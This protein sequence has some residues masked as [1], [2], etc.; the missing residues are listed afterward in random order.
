MA[1]TSAAAA[2]QQ[3]APPKPLHLR[4][5]FLPLALVGMLFGALIS[6]VLV[7]WA[8]MA[9]GLWSLPGAAHAR[10]TLVDDIQYLNADFTQSLFGLSPVELAAMAG[11]A[12]SEWIAS[13]V[14]RLHLPEIYQQLSSQG[15]GL[16]SKLKLAIPLK[17]VDS[18]AFNGISPIITP[19]MALQSFWQYFDAGLYSVQTVVVRIVVALLTL[20][21]YVLIGLACL[22]DGV[23]ARD[24]RKFTA[25]NESAFAYHRYRPW[26]K[27]F[28]IVGWYLYIAWPS[29]IHPNLVFIPSAL[30]CGWAIFNTG[31]WFK[32]FF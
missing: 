5:L 4:I 23:V 9:I 25:A 11:Q 2:P 29:S 22:L 31:K 20:P 21:A 30:L 19:E 16:F 18:G 15:M 13:Q 8:C 24:I 6:A 17:P 7:E 28:F 32:K 12:A 26:A 1:S 14:E 3:A 10:Q 27:R